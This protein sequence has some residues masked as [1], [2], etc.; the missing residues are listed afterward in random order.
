MMNVFF[1]WPIFNLNISPLLGVHNRRVLDQVQQ[2]GLS[3][4]HI[5]DG[6]MTKGFGN[7]IALLKLS[8]PAFLGDRVGLACLPSGDPTDRVPPGTKCFLTGS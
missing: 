1:F 8:S 3:E 6:A 5:N 7:D 4:I 2:I